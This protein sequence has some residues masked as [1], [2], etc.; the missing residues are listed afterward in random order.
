M[1]TAEVSFADHTSS[2]SMLRCCLASMHAQCRLQR[3]PDLCCELLSG[4]G[5]S[6]A[7]LTSLD[8]TAKP[9]LALHCAASPIASAEPLGDAVGSHPEDGSSLDSYGSTQQLYSA[10][11]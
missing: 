8:A 3:I 11:G 9:R 5:T 10:V 2:A 1:R 4:D 6:F 7:A